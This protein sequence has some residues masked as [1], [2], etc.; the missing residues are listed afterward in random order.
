LSFGKRHEYPSALAPRSKSRRI[1]KTGFFSFCH[2]YPNKIVSKHMTPCRRFCRS[3]VD[4]EDRP[5]ESVAIIMAIFLACFLSFSAAG[6]KRVS[7]V[8]KMY[9]AV[10][11]GKEHTNHRADLTSAIL[12]FRSFST[13]MTSLLGLLS[14]STYST[15]SRSG[16]RSLY[17]T[18]S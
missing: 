14:R 4:V 1:K 16:R 11:A 10:H 9:F 15:I 2:T 12:P 6:E 5:H 13:R 7:R 8:F 17:S 3:S 18:I